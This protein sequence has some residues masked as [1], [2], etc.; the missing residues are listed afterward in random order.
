MWIYKSPQNRRIKIL[1]SARSARRCCVFVSFHFL[2][3]A[4]LPF[5]NTIAQISGTAQWQRHRK[6]TEV[7]TPT[8]LAFRA[9]FLIFFLSFNR[10]FGL[11]GAPLHEIQ[12]SN[13]ENHSPSKYLREWFQK[14]IWSFG[15][16]HLL[17]EMSTKIDKE[18]KICSSRAP[19]VPSL[20]Y[21]LIIGVLI[22]RQHCATNKNQNNKYQKHPNKLNKDNQSFADGCLFPSNKVF[23]HW[24]C[25]MRHSLA[26]LFGIGANIF[27][28]IIR[29]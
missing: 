6:R 28:I 3:C 9:K 19:T 13:D 22:R 5:I 16:W 1:L 25:W 29:W 24:P 4:A 21:S 27:L 12:F 2:F 20:C 8:S 17:N 15:K 26:T 10:W 11:A 7:T 14:T 23:P 18:M